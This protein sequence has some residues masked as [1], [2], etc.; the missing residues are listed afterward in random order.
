MGSLHQVASSNL[1]ACRHQYPSFSLSQAYRPFFRQQPYKLQ[2]V[3]LRLVSD[4][5]P[6]IETQ[7]DTNQRLLNHFPKQQPYL[8]VN[9][10]WPQLRKSCHPHSPTVDLLTKPIQHVV[11]N[12]LLPFVGKLPKYQ[13][14]D[15]RSHHQL[16][17]R[18]LL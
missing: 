6:Y 2:I 3:R 11:L 14:L 5:I 7:Y 17:R 10:Y 9:Q 8:L 16:S 4:P 12:S 18:R 13:H 15:Q 1:S